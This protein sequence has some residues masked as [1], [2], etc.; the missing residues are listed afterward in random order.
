MAP[1]EP[2]RGHR[3]TS[4]GG[5]EEAGGRVAAGGSGHRGECSSGSRSPQFPCGVQHGR[6]HHCRSDASNG[7]ER[8]PTPPSNTIL[9]HYQEQHSLFSDSS[10]QFMLI[11]IISGLVVLGYC[12]EVC[13][14]PGRF[15]PLFNFTT[16]SC[17]STFFNEARLVVKC[18]RMTREWLENERLRCLVCSV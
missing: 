3:P 14:P 16:V 4:G 17:S 10:L 6:R 12:S 15:W 8:P 13:T 7:E 1:A 9:L 18:W 5:D 2:Q 11:F